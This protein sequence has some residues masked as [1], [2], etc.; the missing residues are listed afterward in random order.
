[1]AGEDA[2]M[3]DPRPV[4]A[5]QDLVAGT[6]EPKTSPENDFLSDGA[7]ITSLVV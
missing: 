1:M 4:R 3:F 2:V 6:R 7:A 5:E